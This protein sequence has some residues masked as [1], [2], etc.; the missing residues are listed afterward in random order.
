MAHT[1]CDPLKLKHLL[2]K[3]KFCEVGPMV[4]ARENQSPLYLSSE[5]IFHERTKYIEVDCCFIKE[6]IPLDIIKASMNST[7]QLANIFTKS[8]FHERTKYIEVDCRFIKE[9]I[10]LGI[11]RTSSMNL[12]DQLA[13]IFTKSLPGP[14]IAYIYNKLDAYDLY[15]H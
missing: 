6:K 2:Q 9:K 13:N 11:I 14:W 5:S 7:D 8:I 1:T 15:C 3:F 4:Y 12:R 10:P